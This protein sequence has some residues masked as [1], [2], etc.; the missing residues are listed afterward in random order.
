MRVCSAGPVS[1]RRSSAAVARCSVSCPSSDAPQPVRA[2]SHVVW[3]LGPTLRCPPPFRAHGRQPTVS[4]RHRPPTPA[5]VP[6]LRRPTDIW[7]TATELHSQPPPDRWWLP[8]PL[9]PLSG[10]LYRDVI[11]AIESLY[12]IQIQYNIAEIKGGLAPYTYMRRR[13]A[14]SAS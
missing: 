13:Y 1:D 9:S 5:P 2:A 10:C 11:W 12:P 6:A 14:K 3:R 8:A 4:R 7:R